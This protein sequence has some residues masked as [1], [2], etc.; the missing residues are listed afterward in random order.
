MIDRLERVLFIVAA[1]VLAI[2]E[3]NFILVDGRAA[4]PI[5]ATLALCAALLGLIAD[6]DDWS[7]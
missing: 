7:G 2:M 1:F 6:K 5:F 4:I 3:I